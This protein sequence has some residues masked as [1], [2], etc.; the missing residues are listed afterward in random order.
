MQLTC[1]NADLQVIRKN[2]IWHIMHCLLPNYLRN[3]SSL[4]LCISWTNKGKLKDKVLIS[5]SRV[6][7]AKNVS[8][9]R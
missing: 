2:V 9:F 1:P 6:N 3:L 7:G 4:S 5:I 8:F